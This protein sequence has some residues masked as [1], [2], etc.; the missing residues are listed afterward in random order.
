MMQRS[1]EGE[2]DHASSPVPL[3]AASNIWSI[4]PAMCEKWRITISVLVCPNLARVGPPRVCLTSP[5]I[6]FPPVSF[7]LIDIR[8]EAEFASAR[9]ADTP[10]AMCL[11]KIG[12]IVIRAQVWRTCASDRHTAFSNGLRP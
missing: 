6:V 2:A 9:K 11:Q 8:S 1:A 4:L 3:V 5:R 10:R 12:G 7:G